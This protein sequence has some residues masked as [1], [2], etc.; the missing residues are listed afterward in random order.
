VK[1]IFDP[2]GYV[3]NGEEV[4]YGSTLFKNADE[5]LNSESFK[6]PFMNHYNVTIKVITD[7]EAMARGI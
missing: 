2:C 5:W 7:E 3:V 6:S 4:P 1:E